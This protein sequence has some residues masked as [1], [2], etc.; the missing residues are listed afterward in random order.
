MWGGRSWAPGRGGRGPAGA[1]PRSSADSVAAR[2][3]PPAPGLHACERLEE[4]APGAVGRPVLPGSRARAAQPA[5]P[6]QLQSRAIRAD[7]LPRPARRRHRHRRAR[8]REVRLR[9]AGRGR[10]GRPGS[11]RGASAGGAEGGAGEVGSGLRKLRPSA[12]PPL[13]IRASGVCEDLGARLPE[14]AHFP[15]GL[16][17]PGCEQQVRRPSLLPT[18]PT[19]LTRG[20]D[21]ME[22]TFSIWGPTVVKGF[23]SWINIDLCRATPLF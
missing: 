3:A 23:L 22:P 6:R 10:A 21:V 17:I 16:A 9:A 4:P 1:G 12:V 20:K 5:L 11:G 18:Q 8:C 2:G 19:F 7:L 14:S 13:P 15:C